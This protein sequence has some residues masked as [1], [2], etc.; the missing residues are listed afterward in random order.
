MKAKDADFGMILVTNPR[1]GEIYAMASSPS[2]DPNDPGKTAPG[3]CGC[4]TA[5]TDGDADGT[6]DC[7][8]SCPSDPL[9]LVAGQCGCGTPDTDADSVAATVRTS[10]AAPVSARAEKKAPTLEG[11]SVAVAA[12]VSEAWKAPTLDTASAALAA[13]PWSKFQFD[14]LRCA[15]A[16][17]PAALFWGASFPLALAGLTQAG[18]DPAQFVGRAYAANTVGAIAGAVGAAMLLI[19]TL[20]TKYTQS[21]NTT[22]A[23][24][25]GKPV[26]P[27]MGSYGIGVSRLVGAVIEAD[28]LPLSAAARAAIDA[29]PERLAAALGGG[30]DYELLFTAPPE[31]AASIAAVARA[32]D[33]PLTMI[34]RI[35]DGRGMRVLDREGAVM[36][37][38][39][40]G[41][42]HF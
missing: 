34:G 36:T 37:V 9:K 27:E 1:T 38:A 4:G 35:E 30:D 8:D 11:L 26:F 32:I 42:R 10:A 41:Y 3:V 31:V 40:A 28:R 24:P 22:V 19:P 20:G 5:D 16:I 29:A 12:S 2:Y 13:S 23:G 15:V 7:L 21:M 6:A 18:R 33:L 17:L 14:I 25:D 39:V